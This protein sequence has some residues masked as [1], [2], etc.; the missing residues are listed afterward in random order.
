MTGR[1]CAGEMSN[2]VVGAGPV[3]LQPSTH[4]CMTHTAYLYMNSVHQWYVH[5]V[6]TCRPED[7]VIIGCMTALLGNYLIKYDMAISYRHN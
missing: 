3:H 7:V 2:S 6:H 4:S 5:L 1:Q